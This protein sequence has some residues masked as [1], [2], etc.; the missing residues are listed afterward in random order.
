MKLS[1]FKTFYGNVKFFTSGSLSLV[2]GLNDKIYVLKRRN[3]VCCQ[4]W[5]YTRWMLQRSVFATVRVLVEWPQ[6]VLAYILK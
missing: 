6:K 2:S 4:M 1:H 3:L 5:E